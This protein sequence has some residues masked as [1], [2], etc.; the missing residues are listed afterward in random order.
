MTTFSSKKEVYQYLIDAGWQIGRSQF[1]EHCKVK[2]LSPNK[3][4]KFEQKVIDRY[5]KKNLRR[6]ETGQKVDEY[7]ERKAQVQL[8]TEEVKLE[9]EKHELG[10]KKGKFIARDEFELAV[11]GRSV[12]FM[13][14]LNHSVQTRVGDWIDIVGGD[15]NR[16]AELVAAISEEIEQRMGDFAAD[17]EFDVILEME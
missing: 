15:Q 3:E 2:L 17:A 1:Y 14:H 7:Q 8:E 16:A 11:V 9:R 6:K 4:G 12:A 5:A 13:A 10:V